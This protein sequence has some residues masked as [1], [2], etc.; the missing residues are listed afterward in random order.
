VLT[1]VA[2]DDEWE[3]KT[4]SGG[5]EVASVF[6]RTGAVTAEADDY[7][8]ADI[9]ETPTTLAGYGITDAYD[10]TD[11]D[12]R[13]VLESEVGA[14]SGVASL[15]GGGHVPVAQLPASVV[16]ALEYQGTWDANANSP[17]LTSSTG[18]KG[19]FY[20]VLDSR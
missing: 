4:P 7:S 5:G 1:Y 17:A 18:T 19:F 13:Y 12:A 3:P 20:K 2:A 10:K 14:S 15:D 11:A 9:A 16:G 8:F 6:G